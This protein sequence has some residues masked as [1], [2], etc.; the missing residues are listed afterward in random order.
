MRA[1]AITYR[2]LLKRPGF[3]CAV[4]LTL[5]LGIGANSAIFSVIDAVLLK[6]LPYPAADRLVALF[7]S[8]PHKKLSHEG[9]A[10]VRIEEWNRA[11]RSFTAIAGAY[12]ENIAET[13]GELPEMLVSARVSPRFFSLLGTL[14]VVGRTFSPEEDLFNGPSAGIISEKLWRRRFGGDPA[15]LGKALRANGHSYP[16]VGV[17]PDSVTFPSPAVDIWV[18][19]KLP[20]GVM[21]AREARW[22][23]AIGRLK[24]GTTLA[25]AWADLTAVQARL[26]QQFP[27][28]DAGWSPVVEPLK[29]ETVGGVRRS[30][31]ILF[32]SVGFVLLIAC[33]NVACL[34]LARAYR[35]EREIA[36]RFS[37][38]AAR[39]RLI[40][41]QLFEAVCLAVPG[42]LLG[43]ALSIAGTGIFRRAATLLPRTDEIRLDWRIVGFTLLLGL[44][45]ALLFGLIPALRPAQREVSGMLS[46]ASRGQLG[47]SHRMQRTLVSFQIALAIVL[48]TGSGLLLRS[49]AKLGQVSLGFNPAHVLA[50]RVSGSFGETNDYSGLRQRLNRTL[51]ALRA[52]PGIQSAALSMTLPGTGEASPVQFDIPGQDT[53]QEGQKIFADENLVSPDFFQLLGIPILSGE[54][55]RIHPDP[56]A[57]PVAL[58]SRSFADRYFAG[59]DPIGH[60]VSLAG[61]PAPLRISGVV[62]DI[63]Q[64]GYAHDPVPTVYWCGLPSNPFPE[65]LLKSAGDP[66]LLSRAV[67]QTIHGIDPLRAVYDVE[68][69][70][71]SVSSTL[72]E[73]RFQ[74][75]LL[76]SFAATSLLLAAIGLY[77]VTSF[78]VSLR[79]REIGLRAALGATPS[80]IFG[81]IFREGA[82]MTAAGT[83][84]GLAAAAVL[85]RFIAT[86]LFG[87]TPLDPI[88]FVGGPLLLIAVAA[89]ALWSPAWRATEIDPLEALRQD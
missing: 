32:G 12:T 30:L 63:R 26:A 76:G 57:Q 72:A 16:I 52:I 8:N 46:W 80:R 61:F 35:R 84:A 79:T 6:P 36:V 54:T 7:E 66:L 81:Q 58:I 28:T 87:V 86:L 73:R 59:Q 40:R 65:V 60:F 77:G 1:A 20:P 68:R 45:T 2:G 49:L 43:L 24:E 82:L 74:M 41:E 18:P 75:A 53:E 34:M 42:C 19:A 38:G 51:E 47:R 11:S 83:L 69:L 10:P 37:L 62:S 71:D 33:A 56:N 13:S 27:G 17:M 67:R 29:E 55:C 15:V 31:W 88:T 64:H 5:A 89:A 44:I 4:V 85:S 39:G 48:L 22:E 9:V 25:S 23:S 14:P 50:F 70:S 78:L 3:F 21:R